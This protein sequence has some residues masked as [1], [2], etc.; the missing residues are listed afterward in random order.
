M[1]FHKTLW[2]NGIIL[3]IENNKEYDWL[4]TR[5]KAIFSMGNN[6]N[7][8]DDYDEVFDLEGKVLM[9][10]FIKPHGYFS[11]E[12]LS[13]IQPDNIK[14]DGNGL[15]G[16]TNENTFIDHLK[17]IPLPSFFILSC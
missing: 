1:I 16:C 11:K 4:I 17:K 2:T 12:V 15:T 3:D 6:E 13:Y 9:S 5:N 14:K 7:K 8:P 10:A